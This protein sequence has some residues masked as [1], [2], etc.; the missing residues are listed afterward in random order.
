[1]HEV[2]ERKLK[3]LTNINELTTKCTNYRRIR[4]INLKNFLKISTLFYKRLAAE[5][6]LADREFLKEQK[7]ERSS[8]NQEQKLE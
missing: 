4:F 3:T 2:P 5:T 8:Q 6:Q 1:M 7:T